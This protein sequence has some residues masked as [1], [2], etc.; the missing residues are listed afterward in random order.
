MSLLSWNG[1]AQQ[2]R[3]DREKKRIRETKTVLNS[4]IIQMSENHVNESRQ[5]S[6]SVSKLA[7]QLQQETHESR[8]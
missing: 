1:G 5:S 8:G 2:D 4:F 7:Q 3:G 6:T